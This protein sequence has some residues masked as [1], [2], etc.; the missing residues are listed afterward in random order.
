MQTQNGLTIHRVCKDRGG[1][2]IELRAPAEHDPEKETFAVILR[3]DGGGW[4]SSE[5]S[6]IY[7]DAHI[8]IN[9]VDEEYGSYRR[10]IMDEMKQRQAERERLNES[11]A[12]DWQE[13][14]NHYGCATP[15]D[16]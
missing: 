6:A 11:F 2:E 12:R 10:K 15:A 9:L 7:S 1:F 4:K 16:E 13:V 3:G 5:S 8:V 14:V